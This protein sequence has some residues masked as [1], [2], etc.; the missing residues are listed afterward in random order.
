M[1]PRS[2]ASPADAAA[3]A[4]ERVLRAE[5]DAEA[6]LAQSRQQAQARLEAARDEALAIVNRA[7]ERIAHWQ[8]AHAAALEGRLRA[9]QAQAAASAA[10]LHPADDAAITAAAEQVAALLT[11]SAD[12]AASHDV[13]P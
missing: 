6:S 9:L 5:H 1:G 4:V 7:M 12:H 10:A 11:T 8:L 3:R 2:D 13:T